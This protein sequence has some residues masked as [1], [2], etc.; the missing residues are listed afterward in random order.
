MT[1][2]S[3]SS[4]NFFVVCVSLNGY[5][6]YGLKLGIILL[7][8]FSLL[9]PEKIAKHWHQLHDCILSKEYSAMMDVY[10]ICYLV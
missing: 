5:C 10:L 8:S 7:F 4:L 2:E 1:W 9:I 3:D 6:G